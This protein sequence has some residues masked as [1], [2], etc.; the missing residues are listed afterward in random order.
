MCDKCEEWKSHAETLQKQVN[1]LS[2]GYLRQTQ[3]LEACGERIFN[4]RWEI[5]ELSSNGSIDGATREMEN[6]GWHNDNG[7]FDQGE[8]K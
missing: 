7:W 4:L 6:R 3:E 5:C 2:E 8:T 1:I